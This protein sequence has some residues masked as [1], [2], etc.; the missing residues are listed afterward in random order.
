[1]AYIK[2]FKMLLSKKKNF[3]WGKLHREISKFGNF[4]NLKIKSKIVKKS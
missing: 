4:D 2:K 3:Y 1:M